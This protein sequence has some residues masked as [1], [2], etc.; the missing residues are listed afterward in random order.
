MRLTILTC[1]AIVLSTGAVY[2][3]DE[4]H[5]TAA[6]KA[7]CTVDAEKFCLAAYPDEQK[8]L[9]CL[10][11]NIGSLSVNCAAVFKAGLKQRGLHR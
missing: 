1:L 2:A 3:Q 10:R 8:L 5:I 9:V 4:Y 11:A 7:A 6:E